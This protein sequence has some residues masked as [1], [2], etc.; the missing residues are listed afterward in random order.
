MPQVVDQRRRVVIPKHVATTLGIKSGDQVVF[1]KMG[2]RYAIAKLDQ[3]VD[4]LA[5]IMDRDPKR[6]GK[7]LPVSPGEIKKIWKE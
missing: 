7:P 4:R 5:E 6:T 2:D 1:E 3:R